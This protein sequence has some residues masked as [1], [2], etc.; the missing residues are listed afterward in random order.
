MSTAYDPQQR[1]TAARLQHASPDWLILYG[2]WSRHYYA[3]PTFAPTG[4]DPVC[5]QLR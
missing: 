5:P 1:R 3:F 4:N 2:P